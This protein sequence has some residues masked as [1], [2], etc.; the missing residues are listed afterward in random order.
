MNPNPFLIGRSAAYLKRS[1]RRFLIL[2]LNP[3]LIGR[4]A[5]YLKRSERRFPS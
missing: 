4:S 2:I 5:A 1:E 3:F